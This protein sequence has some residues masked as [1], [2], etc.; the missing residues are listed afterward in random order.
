MSALTS[1][2][3]AL[4]FAAILGSTCHA[5]SDDPIKAIFRPFETENASISPDGR[6]LAYS[7]R[8]KHLVH[9]AIRALDTNETKL[10]PAAKDYVPTM[11]GLKEAAPARITFLRWATP[12]RLVLSVDDVTIWA[13]D[14]DGSN[15]LAIV[16]S[17][18]L[19][20]H[21]KAPLRL[22]PKFRGVSIP[23]A[24]AGHDSEMGRGLDPA[25]RLASPF[26]EEEMPLGEGEEAVTTSNQGID[27]R[28]ESSDDLFDGGGASATA[29]RQPFVVEMPIDDP[30]H[31]IVECR[32]HVG[33]TDDGGNAGADDVWTELWKVNIDTGSV[34]TEERE[35]GQTRMYPDKQGRLRLSVS[36][37][38]VV[39]RFIHTPVGMAVRKPLDEETQ[40][41]VALNF[42]LS[43]ETLLGPRS[44]PLGFDFD[45][46]L[47]YFIS[48]VGGDRRGLYS[49]DLK[50]KTRT[51]FCFEHPLFDIGEAER[52]FQED[53]LVFDRGERRLVGVRYEGVRSRVYWLDAEL[54]SLQAQLQT[55]FEKKQSG[56]TVQLAEW[57]HSRNRFI[58]FVSSAT[59]P[60]SYYIFD[61]KTRRLAQFAWRAPWITADNA[62]PSR[63]IEF[64]GAGGAVLR[65]YLTLPRNP[66][67]E[68]SPLLIYCHDG[69]WN[70]DKPGYN[71]GAQA[72]ATMGFAVAQINYR[73]SSGLGLAHL[74]AARGENFDKA[75]LTDVTAAIDHLCAL[76]PLN[77]K[78]VAILGNGYGGYLAL[79]ALQLHPDK[80][81]CA[82]SINA[83]TD[84]TLWANHPPTGLSFWRDV[85]RDFLKLDDAGLERLSPIA[86]AAAI[87]KPLLI[88][89]S[90]FNQIVPP[91]HGQK[92]RDAVLREG[93]SVDYFEMKTE[94]HTQWLP[95]SYV[96]LFRKLEEFF[97][98]S[99]YN[100]KVEEGELKEV[101]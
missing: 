69:P 59:D 8:S 95:G 10:I 77:R 76:Y 3:L 78:L 63:S 94:G 80:F 88:V 74:N 87:R 99:I 30:R 34:T 14:A 28:V 47:L 24:N 25:L 19:K 84:L 82:V 7:F 5:A 86:H 13:I 66:R 35:T 21:F 43:P 100:F 83:P 16:K 6:Y 18:D 54:G 40:D 20:P 64:K 97:N 12:K 9:L 38:P 4:L 26:S 71:R 29:K 58:L 57:D 81:R 2:V 1:R 73:G 60:G 50:T 65:G 45:P 52:P 55:Q 96:S 23:T 72:L 51:D 75:P 27:G 17:R 67:R 48:N 68:P 42:H 39:R 33:P 61:R 15:A 31:V 49:L 62:Q 98:S 37:S 91:V 79:R 92:M 46:N 32:G 53:V 11:S 70:R 22:L 93:A 85:R 89:Q 44:I 41:K 36:Q 90:E 56:A 101:K